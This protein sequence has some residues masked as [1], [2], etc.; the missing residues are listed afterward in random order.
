MSYTDLMVNGT[1]NFMGIEIPV[2][3]GGFGEDKMCV[4][5]RDVA[6]IHGYELFNLNK[7]INNNIK[8]FVIGVDL[9]DLK[10]AITSNNSQLIKELGF[11]QSQIN[12]SKNIYILSERGY[13]MLVAMMDNSNA[14]KWDRMKQFVDG[15]FN[16]KTQLQKYAPSYLIEDPIAR[17]EAWIEEQKAKRLLEQQATQLQLTLDEIVKE[18]T[19]FD[20]FQ[21]K[22]NKCVRAISNKSGQ[23]QQEVWNDVY[24]FL[25]DKHGMNLRQRARNEREKLNEERFAL[26][27]KYYSNATL[28]QKVSILSTVKVLEYITVM[29]VIETYALKYDIV[30]TDLFELQAKE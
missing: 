11:N 5:A 12:A 18:C 2:V 10:L 17:A 15:Y 27:G 29:Q 25:Y 8:Q 19:T 6:E 9:I 30:I 13:I 1:M 22:C 23:P 3:S 20:E 16:M 24:M 7:L 21:R 14:T 26:K 28:K 4:L